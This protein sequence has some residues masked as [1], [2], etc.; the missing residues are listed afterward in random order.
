MRAVSILIE[1]LSLILCAGSISGAAF[2]EQF[3]AG[4]GKREITPTDPIYLSGYA[5]R[6][7][8]SEGVEQPIYARA[9]VL[10]D[11]KGQTSVLVSVELVGV[12]RDFS[13][14]I[15]SR[16]KTKWGIDRA[17]FLIVASHTHCG[18]AVQGN[19]PG[20]LSLSEK[21]AAVIKRHTDKMA[22]QVFSA[23]EDAM[24]KLEPVRLF[25]GHGQ[26]GF[27][28]NRRIF[29]SNGVDFGANPEGPVD[30]EVPVLRVDSLKG[31]VRAIVFGYACHATTLGGDFYRVS[32]DWPG[33]AMKNLEAVYPEATAFFLT[34]CGGD[35]NPQPRG[36]LADVAEHGLE[37]AGA[38]AGVLSR[39]MTEVTAPL[40]TAFD[41]AQLQLDPPPSREIF[42]ERLN[43]Q[44]VY[45]RR[46]AQRN[47]DRLDRGEGLPR[48][49]NAP[50]QVWRFDK[51]LTLVAMSGEV[52]VDYALR[53]KRE[54][55]QERLWVAGYSNDVFAYI[56]SSRI[57]L[58]GGYE[59]EASMLYY[60]FPS[61]WAMSTEDTLVQKVRELVAQLS[62]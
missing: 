21:D 40:K 58:E 41:Q 46:H 8:P 59:A 34:G 26:A 45:V 15:A 16:L 2:G 62:N 12:T 18:P 54:L 31:E 55:G 24:G 61:R 4:T 33:T 23:V 20:L 48:G 42:A 56:P 6:T 47:L 38:V 10:G 3:R 13:E 28:V 5:S 35:A 49:Y 52:V 51:E 32:G 19:L 17:S 14:T 7:K 43:N 25:M 57:L 22:E 53:L 60:D 36:K 27:A 29:T 44:D 39:P 1:I 50:V 9:L 11:S 37:M 30:R